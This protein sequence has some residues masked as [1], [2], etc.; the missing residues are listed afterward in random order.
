MTLMKEALILGRARYKIELL[1]GQW[2]TIL[3]RKMF[4]YIR[5]TSE[6]NVIAWMYNNLDEAFRECL[7]QIYAD[8]HIMMKHAVKDKFDAGAQLVSVSFNENIGGQD[9]FVYEACWIE[10]LNPDLNTPFPALT[11]PQVSHG[12]HIHHAH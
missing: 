4:R 11:M 7:P 10:S 8:W 6:G 9:N 1:G 3:S 2:S 12:A 5:M